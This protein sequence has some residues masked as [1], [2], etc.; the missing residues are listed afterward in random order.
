MRT[1][2][3]R[4]IVMVDEDPAQTI[5]FGDCLLHK[6]HHPL[7]DKCLE[8][9]ATWGWDVIEQY[10]FVPM[11]EMRNRYRWEYEQT[12]LADFITATYEE[13]IE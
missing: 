8:H 7:S 2:R 12:I 4:M 5:E 9:I 3:D 10:G 6:T 13:E 1:E 11:T